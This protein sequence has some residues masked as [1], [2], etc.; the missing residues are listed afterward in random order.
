MTLDSVGACCSGHGVRIKKISV[1][2]RDY[3]QSL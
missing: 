3:A 2:E 1:L